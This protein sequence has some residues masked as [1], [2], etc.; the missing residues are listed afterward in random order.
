MSDTIKQQFDFT[1]YVVI[2]SEDNT[3]LLRTDRLLSVYFAD[4]K[5]KFKGIIASP[6]KICNRCYDSIGLDDENTS[7]AYFSKQ[8]LKD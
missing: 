4:E 7:T 3:I 8:P 6:L 2:E 1:K 5:G